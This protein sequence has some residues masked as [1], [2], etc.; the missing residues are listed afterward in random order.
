MDCIAI[1][2]S[3]VIDSMLDVS[4]V[5]VVIIWV[6]VNLSPR[7]VSS[8]DIIDKIVVSIVWD[9]SN[10]WFIWWTSMLLAISKFAF[11]STV[12]VKSRSTVLE[13]VH[14]ISSTILH[15]LSV[16]MRNYWIAWRCWFNN[17]WYPKIKPKGL[18]FVIIM[19]NKW[20]LGLINHWKSIWFL[21]MIQCDHQSYDYEVTFHRDNII[22]SKRGFGVLGF[23]GFGAQGHGSWPLGEPIPLH[24]SGPFA[25]L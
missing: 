25:A 21:S 6:D 16:F 17:F 24:G 10:Y 18:T 15:H 8:T 13:S 2:L 4:W 11:S 22:S 20:C 19:N 12:L 3:I 23:W 7:H 14:I 5:L 9:T 1:W